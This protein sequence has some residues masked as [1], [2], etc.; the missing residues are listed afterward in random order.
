[1]SAGCGAALAKQFED[2]SG[3]GRR[4][5]PGSERAIAYLEKIFQVPFWLRPLSQGAEGTFGRYVRALAGTSVEDDA[6]ARARKAAVDAEAA[7]RQAAQA[8]E[9]TVE[10]VPAPE[11]GA[12]AA[13]SAAPAEPEAGG[14]GRRTILRRRAKSGA[15]CS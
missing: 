13:A 2:E 8:K 7:E 12:A 9:A 1:M 14:S 4:T 5:G 6:Q 3:P 10:D 11:G 15:P